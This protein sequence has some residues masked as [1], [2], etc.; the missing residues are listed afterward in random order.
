MAAAAFAGLT[1][2]AFLDGRIV[3]KHCCGLLIFDLDGYLLSSPSV[4]Q[5]ASK[6]ESAA[7]ASTL[8]F[9]FTSAT[10]S[11]LT[12]VYTP[13]SASA[14]SVAF[15]AITASLVYWG[16]YVEFFFNSSL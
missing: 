5:S 16:A 13:A 14:S 12:F 10:T 8:I 9:A 7:S 11:A 2:V 6:S 3:D 1:V 4:S 15:V